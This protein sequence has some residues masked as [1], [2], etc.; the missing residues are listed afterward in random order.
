M[1]KVAVTVAVLALGLAACA[2]NNEANNLTA[3]DMYTE[4]AAGTDMNASMNDEAA[5]SNALEN[6]SNSVENAQAAVNNVA[7]NTT[8]NK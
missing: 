6:A 7:E 3:N 2:K 4:N 8:T 1:K 5:A